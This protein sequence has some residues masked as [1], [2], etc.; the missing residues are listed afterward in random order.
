MLFPT[1]GGVNKKPDK[2][3]QE[4]TGS[5]LQ[6]YLLFPIVLKQQIFITANEGKYFGQKDSKTGK[7]FSNMI[8]EE[9]NFLADWPLLYNQMFR[10][11]APK[12]TR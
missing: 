7:N 6:R 4:G 5:H 3:W 1:W 12:K 10:R 11:F 2:G 9:R 8:K